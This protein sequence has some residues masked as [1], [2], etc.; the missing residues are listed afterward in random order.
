MEISVKYEMELGQGIP[1]GY[2]LAGRW[3]LNAKG[4]TLV[5][6]VAGS[7]LIFVLAFVIGIIIRGL[8]RGIYAGQFS[9]D[10]WLPFVIF[11]GVIV[12]IIVLH[13]A[14]HGI[15]FLVLG[16]KPRFGLK[17]IG[18]FLPVAYATSTVPI[19]RNQ[20]LLVCLG[21]FLLTLFLLLIAILA[22]TENLAAAAL[23]AM[24]M[25]A[26]GSVGD[27]IAANKVRRHNR[28][29]LFEDTEDGFSWYIPLP[30]KSTG[31]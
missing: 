8:L 4:R 20:Y 5:S 12:G 21:P 11:L 28:S 30:E 25:N 9:V 24:A 17:L 2:E 6:L 22:P 15:L 3:Q 16:A 7:I 14:I 19:L 13:E 31:G 10:G 23:M 18:K 27:I 29:E 1:S 26:S